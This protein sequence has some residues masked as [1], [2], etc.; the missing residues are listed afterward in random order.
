MIG[1]KNVKNAASR[2]RQK[3]SWAVRTSCSEEPHSVSSRYTSSSVGRRTSSASSS[4]P[5]ASASA[6]SSF[7][8]RVGSR[9]CSTTSSPSAAI[10]NLGLDGTAGQLR[11]RPLAH[12]HAVAQHGDAVRELLGLIQVVRG[13]QDRLAERAQVANR[14]PGRPPRAGVEARRRLVE[15]DQLGIAD[16]AEPEVEPALLAARQAA[17]AGVLLLLQADELDHLV[18]VARRVV[19]AGEDAQ[20]L[21]HGQRGVERRRLQD[22]AEPVAP[23]AAGA[24]RVDSEHLDAAAVSLA[25]ALEDLDGRRL[26]GAVRA[27]QP[28]DLARCDLE[29]DPP[30]RLERAVALAQAGDS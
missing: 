16:Q 22:D 15:E 5:R 26:P 29:V 11:R 17:R 13:E 1:R 2:L 12:D 28:E 27:E 3:S 8:R 14:L 18:D 19:V 21:A 4:S 24:L 20:A 23:C 7:S 6:V 25:V 30:H 10:A 9:V